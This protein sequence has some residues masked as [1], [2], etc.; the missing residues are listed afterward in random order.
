MSADDHTAEGP[1][2]AI[3][4]QREMDR[5]SWY[6]PRAVADVLTA[7]VDE[8]H[9]TTRRPKWFVLSAL[10]AVALDHRDEVRAKL[11]VRDDGTQG[12]DRSAGHGTRE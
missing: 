2:A 1:A 9:F 10:V 11:G 7:E 5:R 6:M 3:P 4:P 12:A 8:L